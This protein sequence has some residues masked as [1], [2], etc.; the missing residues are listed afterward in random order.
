MNSEGILMIA[1]SHL[2]MVF[3][4]MVLAAVIFFASFIWAMLPEKFRLLNQWGRNLLRQAPS[5]MTALGLFGTFYGLTDSLRNFGTEVE[6]IQIFVNDLKSV[7]IYSI[8]G[9]GSAAVFMVLNVVVNAIY[10]HR[11]QSEKIKLLQQH[12]QQNKI[13]Q[14]HN[15]D[16][17]QYLAAQLN[18]TQQL[19]KNLQNQQINLNQPLAAAAPV[20]GSLKADVTAQLSAETQHS[21]QKQ[22]E[23]APYLAELAQIQETLGKTVTKL[24]IP[25]THHATEFHDLLLKTMA[26]KMDAQ[27]QLLAQISQQLQQQQAL[28]QEILAKIQQ[29]ISTPAPSATR[30]AAVDEVAHASPLDP[31]KKLELELA[32]LSNE[33]K[34]LFANKFNRQP[35]KEEGA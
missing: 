28:N 25:Y 4:L 9:I 15:E 35:E 23:F 5:I 24:L 30:A 19:A 10:H 2:P 7:F 18:A 31:F 34:K 26:E 8:L 32:E 17:L 16:V 6:Q 11:S 20:S 21:L 12:N 13:A 27:A 29:P 3:N 33:N 14:R 1:R 22:A